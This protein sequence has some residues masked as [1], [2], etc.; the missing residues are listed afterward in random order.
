MVPSLKG[1]RPETLDDIRIL[2]DRGASPRNN[3]PN[4]QVN[5]KRDFQSGR[6]DRSRNAAKIAPTEAK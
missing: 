6:H 1:M 3:Q 5:P 4:G 2:E